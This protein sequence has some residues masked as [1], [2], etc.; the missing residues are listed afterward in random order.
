MDQPGLGV[1][2]VPGQLVCGFPELD[3]VV[4]IHIR[5]L[6]GAAL[7]RRGLR[8]VSHIQSRVASRGP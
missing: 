6:N 4:Q 8:H 7:A 5:G 3:P 1:G 2:T